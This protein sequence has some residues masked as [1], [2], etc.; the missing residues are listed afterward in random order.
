LLWQPEI[1]LFAG[2]GN[3]PTWTTS[4]KINDAL[5][6]AAA[7]NQ[8]VSVPYA[9]S[10]GL[11][12]F[13]IATWANFTTNAGSYM[14]AEKGVSGTDK[15]FFYYNH[16]SGGLDC[17]FKSGSTIYQYIYTWLPTIGTWYH[18]ACAYD[19][20]HVMF[21]VNGALV[22]SNAETHAPLQTSDALASAGAR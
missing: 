19:G 4:G 6:F 9:S 20:A 12:A 3:P 1:H 15:Y 16:G 22:Q 17:G 21:F 14:F 10:L 13:T 2:L 5:T 18:L 11:S 8:Y 7:S